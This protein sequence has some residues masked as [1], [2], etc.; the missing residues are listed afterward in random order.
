VR[1]KAEPEPV[2]SPVNY[3]GLSEVAR[4]SIITSVNALA[5]T[6]TKL[7]WPLRAILE[8]TAYQLTLP[9]LATL[10]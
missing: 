1:S 10:R 6:L 7:A 8:A 9:S 3:C 2:T 4:H 5:L